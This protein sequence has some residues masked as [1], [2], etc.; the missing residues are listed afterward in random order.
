MPTSIGRLERVA[1]LDTVADRMVELC[2]AGNGPA[3]AALRGGRLGHPLYP[4]LTDLPIG[5]WT[6]AWVLD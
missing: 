3:S 4:A 6:S 1:R 5:F 2:R